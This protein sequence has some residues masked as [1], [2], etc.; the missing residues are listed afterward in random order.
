MYVYQQFDNGNGQRTETSRQLKA[1]RLCGMQ[2]A[3]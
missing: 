2:R 3:S 1:G